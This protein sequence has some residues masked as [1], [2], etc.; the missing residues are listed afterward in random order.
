M[1]KLKKMVA[2][3]CPQLVNLIVEE[4]KQTPNGVLIYS[5]NCVLIDAQVNGLAKIAESFGA[6]WSIFPSPIKGVI[7]FIIDYRYKNQ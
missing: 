1:E 4:D 2:E 7:F 5:P 3:I 6:S